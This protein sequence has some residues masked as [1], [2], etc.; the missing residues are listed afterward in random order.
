MAIKAWEIQY[1]ILEFIYTKFLCKIG[2]HQPYYEME[3]VGL[4]SVY[5]FCY[6]CNKELK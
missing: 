6:W 3:G 5:K 2:I 1:T 4:K